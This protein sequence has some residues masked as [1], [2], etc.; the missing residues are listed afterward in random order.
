MDENRKTEGFIRKLIVMYDLYWLELV[1]GRSGGSIMH[2]MKAF[3]SVSSAM[4]AGI[5]NFQSR[6]HLSGLWED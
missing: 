1:L 5:V 2:Y 6:E 4:G 3:K